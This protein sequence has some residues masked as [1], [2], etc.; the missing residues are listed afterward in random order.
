MS[1]TTTSPPVA[2]VSIEQLPRA[3]S[4]S[5]FD[6]SST[7][8][9]SFELTT[10]DAEVEKH[11]R[12]KRK[13]TA[14]K[15]KMVLEEA[16]RN[17]PK[18]DKQARLDIV[19]R[20]SLNEKEVQIWFQNRRQNDRR[21][22][23][24]LSPEE[25]A[26]LRFGGMQHISSDLVTSPDG[27]IATDALDRSFPTSDPGVSRPSESD[28]ASPSLGPAKRE[29]TRSYSDVVVATP[30]HRG[31]SPPQSRTH[32][33][34][35]RRSDDSFESLSR[36][37]SNPVGYLANRW[38]LGS[39]FSTPST[40]GRGVDDSLRLEPFQ[41][42]SCSSDKTDSSRS[43]SQSRFR[44]S[45]SLEG[46]A[47]L[48]SHHQ[49]SP[50]RQSPSLS[51]PLLFSSAQPR[52]RAGLSRSHSALPSV[53]LPPITALTNSLPPRLPRGRSRDVQAWES[54][55]DSEKRDELMAQA[56]HESSGSA[57][58]AISLL[59]SSSGILQPSSAKR[60]ASVS[61][62]P[63][64]HQAKKA[65][66]SRASST[67]ARLE[68]G[69]PAVDPEKLRQNTAGKVNV[70]MLVSPT[71]SDKENWSPD[72]DG[73]PHRGHRRQPLPGRPEFKSTN[74]RR[75]GRVLRDQKVPPMLGNRANTAPCRPSLATSK[76]SPSVRIFEDGNPGQRNRR[77]DDV[78]RFMRGEVSPSKKPDMDCVAG[79][80]SLSQ[81]AWR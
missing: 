2:L 56:E 22:S 70:S 17:N 61:R 6:A 45:L 50:S 52:Q 75:A 38:N 4:P 57:I 49:T 64:P 43:K 18:P 34:S 16:Y 73:T 74:P 5:H 25:L 15:D 8:R 32:E 80:L 29:L 3:D 35:S 24:P 72:E 23:R 58:A 27:L 79:L 33:A 63:R 60:N 1:T 12:G 68:T 39:S 11:P 44:L 20:V 76:A 48:I 28:P 53:T 54:C 14:A 77:E 69:K 10:H 62:P 81:G 9:T 55:A 40:L 67:F 71:D 42:S 19:H 21:K 46:K 41:P 31:A 59:R 65:K 47:E 7:S 26:A 30:R 51:P 78:E 13:R 36:S 66:L 37:F